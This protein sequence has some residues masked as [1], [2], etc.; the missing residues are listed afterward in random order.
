MWFYLA[1]LSAATV[2]FRRVRDKRLT[3]QYPDFTLSWLGQALSL[4]VVCAILAFSGQF[5]NPSLLGSEFWIPTLMVGVLFYPFNSYLY[6]QAIKRGELSKVIPIQSLQPLANV[7]T[8]LLVLSEL[9]T[10][11]GLGGIMCMVLG[12]YALHLKQRK[13]HNPLR[14]FLEEKHSLYML[15]SVACIAICAVLDKQAIL[16]SNAIMY[17]F[18]STCLGVI[19]LYVTARAYKEPRLHIKIADIKP[20]IAWAGMGGVSSTSYLMA[21]GLGPVAYVSAVRGSSVLI[22]ALLGIL[23]LKESL[24]RPKIAAFLFIATGSVV[25]AMSA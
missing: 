21:L 25:L 1:L 4:P 6:L 11:M 17:S 3:I 7:T 18:V 5:T 8:G 12:V 14:P 9:P 19:S 10:R 23:L 20:L 22:T 2:A 13:L 15:L 16:A 24:T